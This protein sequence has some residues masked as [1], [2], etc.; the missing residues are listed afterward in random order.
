LFASRFPPSD[1]EA[2]VFDVVFFVFFDDDDCVFD[3]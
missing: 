3:E 1:A 2:I